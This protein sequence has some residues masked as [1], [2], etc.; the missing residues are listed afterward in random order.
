MARVRGSRRRHARG[1]S[2]AGPGTRDR[3]SRRR[4]AHGRAPPPRAAPRPPLRRGVRAPVVAGAPRG[5]R[6]GRAGD[7]RG[8][9][10]P[11]GGAGGGAP[12]APGH[13]GP[14]TASGAEAR[15]GGGG[16]GGRGG[17]GPRARLVDWDKVGVG[18]FS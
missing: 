18:P 8:G 15:G 4:A 14:T 13:G 2:D 5:G 10:G 17:G 16:G 1:A 3:G 7:R 6:P 9:G 11:R 12:W